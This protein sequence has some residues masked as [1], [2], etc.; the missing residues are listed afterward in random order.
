MQL[1]NIIAILI[2]LT[3]VLGYLVHRFTNLPTTI[4]LM[5]ISL[6][7]SMVIIILGRFGIGFA[8]G[9]SF[10]NSIDFNQ[11][12][13]IGMLSFLLFAGALH[14]DLNELMEY[15]WEV[16]I[17]AVFGVI[18]STVLIGSL[19]YIMLGWMG[20]NLPYIYCLLFGAI[21]SPTDPIAVLSIMKKANAPKSLEIKMAGESLFNDGI[22]VVVFLVIFGIATGQHEPSFNYITSLFAIEVIGGI[23]FGMLL[24]WVGFIMLKSVDNYQVEVLITLALVTGGYALALSMHTSGP[25]A[26]VVAGLFI[27]NHGRK[28][29]MSDR[30]REHLDMFWELVDETLN[31]VLFVLIGLELLVVF[32]TGSYIIA[33]LLA[34]VI[35]LFARVTSIGLPLLLLKSIRNTDPGEVKLLIWGGLRGGI[36]VALALS[37]PKG[38]ERDVILAMTYIVVVFSIVVQ[39]LTIKYLIKPETQSSVLNAQ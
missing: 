19:V 10:V 27:G 13:M 16:T 34:I 36:S 6:I 26:I 35:V 9:V 8:E 38:D 37:L 3:A 31:S 23:L 14:V 28:F 1:F 21:I 20:I 15:K 33:G 11:T 18:I 25:L 30:T 22:A 5:I 7:I 4:G 32:L 12:L 2:S 24:G 29:A 39:G 17:L